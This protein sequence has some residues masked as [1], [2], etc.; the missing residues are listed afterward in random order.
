[1]WGCLSLLT[2]VTVVLG[3]IKSGDYSLTTTSWGVPI[4]AVNFTVPEISGQVL[5]P[6]ALS[7]NGVFQLQVNGVSNVV[8]TLQSSVDLLDRTSISTNSVGE[9]VTDT[10][11][12]AA[13]RRF[14]R[15]QFNQVSVSSYR[16]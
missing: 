9:P 7:F 15:V 4:S 11:S 5:Q 14:Y 6:I 16:P 3:V 10:N 8:Y 13:S 1:M 2:D 12:V